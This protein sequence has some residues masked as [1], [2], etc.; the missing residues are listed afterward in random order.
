[1]T[2]TIGDNI[3][4]KDTSIE[5]KPSPVQ[6][7]D[8]A[9]TQPQR[10]S[11]PTVV[12]HEEGKP[13]VDIHEYV[14]H[15]PVDMLVGSSADKHIRFY[16]ACAKEWGLHPTMDERGVIELKFAFL[17]SGFDDLQD[18]GMIL[19]EWLST[20]AMNWSQEYILYDYKIEWEGEEF[21]VAQNRKIIGI[22]YDTWLRNEIQAP[23]ET[24]V[25]EMKGVPGAEP[26][27]RPKKIP[28]PA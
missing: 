4:P 17:S 25:S 22:D 21:P 23:F 26:I 14:I 9:I 6:P 3:Q 7:A 20:Y 1:M 24:F 18:F 13:I 27:Q 15:I 28:V 8:P 11:E 16:D 10:T 19:H 2:Y 5:P 12:Y